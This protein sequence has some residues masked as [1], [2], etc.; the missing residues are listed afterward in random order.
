MK[1][2]EDVLKKVISYLRTDVSGVTR[3]NDLI[4]KKNT[5]KGDNLLLLI[6]DQDKY[7][8]IGGLVREVLQLKA[9]IDVSPN[10]EPTV[11]SNGYENLIT[12][13]IR[14]SIF[15]YDTAS[16]NDY[17]K[18]LRYQAILFNALKSLDADVQETVAIETTGSNIVPVS[19]TGRNA[20]WASVDFDITIAI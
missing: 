6:T 4:N 8:R 11:E 12:F 9:W 20:M 19:I 5:E 17:I 3:L 15:F 16:E 14:T 10:G 18:A 1:D 13:N 2:L 7:Y